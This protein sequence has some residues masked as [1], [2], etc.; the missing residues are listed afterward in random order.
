MGLLMDFL[1]CKENS[2]TIL[3]ND[4]IIN[5]PGEKRNNG[6]Q[7]GSFWV[8]YRCE[9]QDIMTKSIWRFMNIILFFFFIYGPE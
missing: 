3:E 8:V 2:E 1:K 7:Y 5:H 9:M 4:I 6:G